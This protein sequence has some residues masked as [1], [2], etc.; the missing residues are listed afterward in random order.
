MHAGARKPKAAEPRSPVVVLGGRLELDA[1]ALDS[2]D[3]V[4]TVQKLLAR[5][6]CW[7]AT[8]AA[9]KSTKLLRWP[10]CMQKK[11]WDCHEGVRTCTVVP[12]PSAVHQ[13]PLA[14][15]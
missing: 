11:S 13:A 5:A 4:P 6:A 15:V 8:L 3:A 9:L 12:Y 14:C 10:F 1:A 7:W 2:F